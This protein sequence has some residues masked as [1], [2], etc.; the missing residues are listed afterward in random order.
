MQVPCAIHVEA[1]ADGE[2]RLLR[3]L[4]VPGD[5]GEDRDQRVHITAVERQVDDTVLVHQSAE[6]DFPGIHQRHAALHHDLL[7]HLAEFQLSVHARILTDVQRDSLARF[8]QGICVPAVYLNSAE[9]AIL[10]FL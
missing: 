5:S 4:K 6:L 1:G 3:E 2:I 9:A 10:A 8:P 7:R